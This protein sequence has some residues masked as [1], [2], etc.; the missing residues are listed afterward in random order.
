M[1]LFIIF[2]D[3]M[4]ISMLGGAIFYAM[5]LNK[6]ISYLQKS[7]SEFETMLEQFIGSIVRAQKALDGIKNHSQDSYGKM[8]NILNQMEQIKIDT[9]SSVHQFQ[10]GS[11]QGLQQGSPS[12]SSARMDHHIPQGL[13]KENIDED[14]IF[15]N[16]PPPSANIPVPTK[17][18]KLENVLL[19]HRRKQGLQPNQQKNILIEEL[20]RISSQ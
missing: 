2:M 8:N 12:R 19:E 18:S 16:L 9:V 13:M 1:N 5:K 20:K 15:N 10:Q 6:S 11:Q 3:L 17:G 4:V 7:K 14:E